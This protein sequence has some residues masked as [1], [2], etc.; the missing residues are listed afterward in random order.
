MT[1]LSDA[2]TE[3]T[4]EAVDQF[5]NEFQMLKAFENPNGVGAFDD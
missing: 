3:T 5:L 4:S 1:A 2:A